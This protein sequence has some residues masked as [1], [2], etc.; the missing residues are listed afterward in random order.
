MLTRSLL[1]LL[2][3]QGRQ[4]LPDRLVPQALIQLCQARPD[5]QEQ[6]VEVVPSRFWSSQAR[7]WWREIS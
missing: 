6:T 3:Q 5:Q 1:D 2:E 4:V 7:I